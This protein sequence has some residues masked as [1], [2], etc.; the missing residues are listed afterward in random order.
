M[1]RETFLKID[2]RFTKS[3][4]VFLCGFVSF[5]AERGYGEN[6][7]K[8]IRQYIPKGTDF[9]ADRCLHSQSAYKINRRPRNKLNFLS[10][11]IVFFRFINNFAHACRA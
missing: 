10:P 9:D 1:K 5:M 3:R 4:S 11:K 7:D 6:A 2:Y 8:L